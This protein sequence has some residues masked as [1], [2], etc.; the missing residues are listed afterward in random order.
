MKKILLAVVLLLVGLPAFAHNTKPSDTVSVEAST[1][2]PDGAIETSHQ[3]Y[4]KPWAQI[5][6]DATTIQKIEKGISKYRSSGNPDRT[7]RI[8]HLVLVDNDIQRALVLTELGTAIA[9]ELLD[10]RICY[11]STQGNGMLGAFCN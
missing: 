8:V 6:L 7:Y 3:V 5:K 11:T 10:G 4:S 9:I 2:G 1:F